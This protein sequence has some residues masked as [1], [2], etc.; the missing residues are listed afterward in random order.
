MVHSRLIP[1]QVDPA[2]SYS[3]SIEMDGDLTS[4]HCWVLP[5]CHVP[6]FKSHDCESTCKSTLVSAAYR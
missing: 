2:P 1:D 4:M 5:A 6:V 3:I